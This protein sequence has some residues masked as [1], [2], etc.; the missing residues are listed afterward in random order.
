[1]VTTFQFH[2]MDS[3]TLRTTCISSRGVYSFNSIEWILGALYSISSGCRDSW[4]FQFHWMDSLDEACFTLESILAMT[5]NSIEWIPVPM[6]LCFLVWGG[7][8]LSIPLNG[9]LE[10]SRRGETVHGLILSIPLN[11]FNIENHCCERQT[12]QHYTFNSIEWIRT[13]STVGAPA[14]KNLSIPLNGFQCKV[15]ATQE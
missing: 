14:D 5:F 8:P 9:F 15:G 11:G 6:L 7:P 1:M 10:P 2:W 4:S 3:Y 13:A 12:R